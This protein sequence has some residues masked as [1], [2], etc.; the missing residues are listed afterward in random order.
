V[1]DYKG[2][3]KLRLWHRRQG[4]G[5]GPTAMLDGEQFAIL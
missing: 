1:E 4:C 2:H 5:S 3:T